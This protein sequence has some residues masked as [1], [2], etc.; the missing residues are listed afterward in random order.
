MSLDDPQPHA[1]QNAVAN[2]MLQMTTGLTP[3]F[4]AGNGLRRKL[5]ADGWSP[6]MAEQIAA[7]VVLGIIRKI[8]DSMTAS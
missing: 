5:E 7:E 4:E 6:L 8:N 3:V 1:V 2:A